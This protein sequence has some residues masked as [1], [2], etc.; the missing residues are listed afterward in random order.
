MVE[1]RTDVSFLLFSDLLYDLVLM[2]SDDSDQFADYLHAWLNPYGEL[3]VF[4]YD[5]DILPGQRECNSLIPELCMFN[6]VINN[7]IGN[8]SASTFVPRITA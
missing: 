4:R 7:H 3:K 5:D 8:K 6:F 1:R 2:R